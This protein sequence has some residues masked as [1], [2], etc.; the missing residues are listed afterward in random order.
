[1]EEIFKLAG[2]A[3]V[4]GVLLWVIYELKKEIKDLKAE[5]KDLNL[6]IRDNQK[7][8]MDAMNDQNKMN[9][10]LIEYLHGKD[11]EKKKR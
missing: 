6:I 11:Q 1:M 5:N 9:N 4:V 3:S 8:A 10:K 7:E 2:G